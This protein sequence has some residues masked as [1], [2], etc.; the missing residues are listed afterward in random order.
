MKKTTSNVFA[1]ILAGGSGTRLWPLSRQSW[2]KQLLAL[3]GNRTLLQ[4]TSRRILPVIPAATQFVIT[5]QEYAEQ[6][7]GQMTEMFPQVTPQVLAEPLARNTA[8]AILWGALLAREQ[9]GKDAILA[10]LPSDHL[11]TAEDQFQQQLADAVELARHGW[12]VTFGIKPTH[13]ETGFGYIE[14]G[15]RIPGT[16]GLKVRRFVEKPDQKT[17]D[18]YLKSGRY[19]WNSGMFVFHV[20]TL[21]AELRKHCPD[22]MKAFAELKTAEAD[23]LQKTFQTAPKISIDYAVME[24]TSKAAMLPS[25]FGWSDVGSWY[26]LFEVSPKDAGGNVVIGNHLTIDTQSSLIIGRDRTIA[27]LGVKDLAVIDTPDA[28][29][30]CPLSE[31]QRVR[32][33]VERLN[34]TQRREVREHLTVHRPWGSYTILEEGPRYKIKRIVVKPGKRLSLQRHQHRNEHWVVVSGT[35]T[36]RRDN[37]ELFVRENHSIY[38]QATQ[39]HRLSNFGRIPLQII[40]IQVGGYLEEDDIERYDDDW[41]RGESNGTAPEKK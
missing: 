17:A 5:S 34:E 24:K 25:T 12:L 32:E 8:P 41:G 38:I 31:S 6:V 10:V 3:I 16:K 39:K 13:P 26:S 22:L 37:E 29:L 7:R 40:E 2:P 27:T 18:G 4:D 14:Q 19:T 28:L 33:I 9:G 20:E 35:A 30:V 23:S 36:V 21:L 15:D 1:V 11:I